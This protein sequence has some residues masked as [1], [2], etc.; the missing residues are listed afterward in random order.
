[1]NSQTARRPDNQ[2]P[3]RPHRPSKYTKQTAR[4]EGKRDGKPLIFGWG[5]HLSHNQKV[6]VQRR[7]TWIAAIS[8]LLLIVVVLVGFWININVIIPGL[9]IT[10]VNGHQIPQ[11][12]FRKMVAF[13]AELAQNNLN[14]PHG[15]TTQSD[16]LRKQV[17]AQQQSVETTNKQITD[18]NKQINALP[19]G[20]SSQRTSLEQQLTAAKTQLTTE[21]TTLTTLNQQYSALSQSTIPQARSNFNQPQVAN[22]SII[23]L[24]DDEL[25]REWLTN[26]SNSV[27]AQ[28]NP[29]SSAISRAMNDF[30]ANIPK[31]TSYNAFLSNDG[32]SNDDMQAMMTIKVRRD[33]MQTYLASQIVSPTYQV[34]ARTMT[35]DTLPN[36]QKILNQLK[37]GEDFGKLAKAKSADAGTSSKGGDLGWLARGQYAETY[38]AAVVENWMFD[39]TRKLDEISPIL[40]ENGAFHIVQILGIDPSRKVDPTILQQLK[41]NALSNWLD[42]QHALPTTQLTDINQTM[43]LDPMNMPPDLPVGAQGSNPSGAPGGIPGGIPGG[44]PSNGGQPGQP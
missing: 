22:D 44:V 31:T 20:P 38:S 26:Q 4:F 36:A 34:L 28:V 32:V 30:Q 42:E 18:L 43:L 25:I 9:P 24:Q 12:L 6:Q 39:P 21:Q 35:I 15:L 3:T 16:S 14:G 7:A 10:S 37:H 27:Q 11:S 29:T 33:N 40:K 17:A 2:R 23:W 1:M 5:G 41:S 13:K 19:A 8:F